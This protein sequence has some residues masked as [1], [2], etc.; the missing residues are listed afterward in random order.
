MI[1]PFTRTGSIP[2]G[3]NP[4]ARRAAA[5][6]LALLTIAGGVAGLLL[7]RERPCGALEA[8]PVAGE[9]SGRAPEPPGLAVHPAAT[10]SP[11]EEPEAPAIERGEISGIVLRP[12]GSP[13]ARAY[14]S[15]RVDLSPR[16]PGVNLSAPYGIATAGDD[17]RFV[18]P[19]L[20]APGT[21]WVEAHKGEDAASALATAGGPEVTIRLASPDTSYATVQVLDPDGRPVKGARV[22]ATEKARDL[23]DSDGRARLPGI[24]DDVPRTLKM[25]P[26]PSR[27][28][29]RATYLERWSR[30][31]GTVRME[32]GYSIRGRVVDT[33]GRPVAKAAIRV[34]PDPA[35]PMFSE[36][37][38]ADVTD[39][40][41]AFV[42]RMRRA[43]DTVRL[44]AR[45]E[46]I[47][48][49][50]AD[51]PRE[52]ARSG[53]GDVVLVVDR[54]LDLVVDVPDEDAAATAY[55]QREGEGESPPIHG[56]KVM[57]GSARLAGLRRDATYAVFVCSE[58]RSACAR[59]VG[60][61]PSLGRVSV[62][63]APSLSIEGRVTSAEP[64]HDPHVAVASP[65]VRFDARSAPDGGFRFEG[66][67]PGTH[68]LWA[69]GS[70]LAGDATYRGGAEVEAGGRVELPLTRVR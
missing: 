64:L 67:P 8:E 4:V 3:R 41:G 28:D 16:R 50:A 53:A 11:A 55:A 17:G 63:L 21:Y 13:C 18:I 1:Q 65:G 29:L 48:D 40:S 30:R 7:A 2:G 32:R 15:A 62:T 27:E 36:A 14:L 9:D 49:P 38:P 6:S 59:L 20:P 60:V 12:D 42:V 70:P 33:E 58:D 57:R 46:W 56:E 5:V 45:P 37:Q 51:S 19:R 10:P 66:L 26:P 44:Y 68:R 54:G 34:A 52:E 35:P 43:D 69:T 61:R 24:D 25:V 23:T 47:P 22:S 31:Q 39:A